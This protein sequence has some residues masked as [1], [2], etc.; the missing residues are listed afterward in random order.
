MERKRIVVIE[1]DA[2]MATAL[3]TQLSSAGYE[4][5]RAAD[6]VSGLHVVSTTHP[7]LV[8]VD[9]I[10]RGIRGIEIIRRMYDDASLQKVPV[11]ILT[12]RDDDT[13]RAKATELGVTSYLIKSQ[14]TLESVT[15]EVQQ[16]LEPLSGPQTDIV[17]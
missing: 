3:H 9:I 16:Y 11:I 5:I 2:D 1:D 13:E 12:N 4:V 7:D 15:R 8:I 14:S 10:L 6:G 17:L